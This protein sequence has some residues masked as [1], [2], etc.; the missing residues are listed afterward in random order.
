MGKVL[1]QTMTVTSV[2]W[3][4][5]ELGRRASAEE[6]QAVVEYALLLALI[7]LTAFGIVNEFGLG[8]SGLYSKIVAN[9]P[10]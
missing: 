1:R 7:A 9:F 8:V 4:L 10:H 2:L 5:K 6:G 3:R